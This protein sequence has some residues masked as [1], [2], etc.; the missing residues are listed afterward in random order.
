MKVI[1]VLLV[2]IVIAIGLSS[3]YVQN[4]AIVLGHRRGGGAVCNGGR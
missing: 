4:N 2:L 1:K 3:C